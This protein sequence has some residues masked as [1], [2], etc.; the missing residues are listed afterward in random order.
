M[1]ADRPAEVAPDYAET[2]YA[3][4]SW[5]L[6]AL[7]SAVVVWWVF[8]LATPM[9]VAVGA[10]VLTA[11][12]AGAGVWSYG[13]AS[14][15]VRAGTVYAGGA[16]IEPAYC[17]AATALD[18]QR[19]AAVRGPEADARAYLLLRP[20]IDTAVR[21]EVDDPRDPTPYWL[22]SCR[23]PKR[24]AAAIEAALATGRTDPPGD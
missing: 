8:V 6:A 7:G 16:S 12:S 9:A 10:A 11:L 20:Y 13:R 24:F 15:G 17:A 19:T 5:W 4:V 22:I 21:L 1:P 23:H 14:I 18:P 2:L 3:P